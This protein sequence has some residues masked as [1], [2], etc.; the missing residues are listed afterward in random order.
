M[1]LAIA[2]RSSNL[3]KVLHHV[4]VNDTQVGVSDSRL[5]CHRYRHLSPLHRCGW[6]WS[7]HAPTALEHVLGDL[8]RVAEVVSTDTAPHHV[9]AIRESKLRLNPAI[10]FCHHST[11][12][13][14][15]TTRNASS[16]TKNASSLTF[17]FPNMTT[18]SMSQL[19]VQVER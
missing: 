6:L 19:Q 13:C 12:S 14:A 15:H 16:N 11:H 1:K 18:A 8:V 4:R 9:R 17:L 2:G 5:S 10:A 3:S 7:T